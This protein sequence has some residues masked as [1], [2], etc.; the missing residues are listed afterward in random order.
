V[1]SGITQRS[2]QTSG[3]FTKLPGAVAAAGDAKQLRVS[4][5]PASGILVHALTC[6]V[7]VT[8]DI[9]QIVRYLKQ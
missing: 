9:E 7:G 2:H 8:F 1:G 3:F 6:L 5:F 4:Q